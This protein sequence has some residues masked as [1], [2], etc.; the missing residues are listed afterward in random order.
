MRRGRCREP[1]EDSGRTRTRS[2]PGAQV[3]AWAG[4]TRDVRYER[5]V[6]QAGSNSFSVTLHPRLTVIAGVGPLEREGLA[7]EL[8]GALGSS[9]SGVHAELQL[10]DGRHLAV[11][12]PEGGRHRVVDID[13]ATDVSREFTTPEGRIDVLAHAGID[14]RRARRRLRL[15]AADLAT[16]TKGAAL[17]RQLADVDQSRL[18]SAAEQLR[19]TDD[20]LQQVAEAVGSAPED[21]AVIDKIEQRHQAFEAAQERHERFR[22]KSIGIAITGA[23]AAVPIAFF[24]RIAAFGP[25]FLASIT[26]LISVVFRSLMERAARAEEEALA[27]A[28]AQS[29]LGFHLQRVNGLLASDQ[30]R[31]RLMTAADEHNKAVAAWRTMAGDIQVDWA[32]EHREEILAAARLRRD[33]TALGAMSATAPDADGDRT[34]DLARVLVGRL[35]EL[36]H[37]GADGESFPL[38]LDE[39]FVGLDPGMKPS[40]LELLGNSAGSPQLIL[41]T[42]DEEVASWAR[43]EALTGA[44]SIIEPAP[45]PAEPAPAPL[46]RRRISA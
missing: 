14:L 34:A 7:G 45:E 25:L 42:E 21:A 28:G 12:R 39:P 6:I 36:R 19:R 2:Q 27:E 46:P 8:I 4:R 33:I 10:D 11:F 26:V 3:G 41:L 5:L 22:A 31:K 17:I 37:L 43:L 24:N 23:V 20:H 1:V 15:G 29:Y 9:R 40:L 18:W 44:L 38:I 32:F 16:G 13:R 35:A 30:N